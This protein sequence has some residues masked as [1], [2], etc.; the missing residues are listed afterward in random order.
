MVRK[1]K[2][3]DREPI[4]QISPIEYFSKDPEPMP[5]WLKN[6]T[7]GSLVRIRDIGDSRIVYYPGSHID[8]NP[9]RL[10]NTAHGAH[11]FIYVDYGYSRETLDEM[12]S[13]APLKGYHLHHEQA[14]SKFELFPHTLI[15]HT[16][17][18]EMAFAASGCDM[19]IAPKKA[20]AFLQIYERDEGYSE[21]YGAW[22]FA[23]IYIA[24]DANVTY[25]ALFSNTGVSPYACVVCANMGSEYS[26]FVSGSLLEKIAERTDCFPQY[27]LCR[28]DQGW[29]EYKMLQAVSGT[30]P[31]G[32]R[33][34]WI[35][36]DGA[37]DLDGLDENL[38]KIIA[39]SD[40]D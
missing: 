29:G 36:D 23:L 24:A 1:H 15:P 8:G 26:S 20:F 21:E 37:P 2:K 38:R 10:F 35:R 30:G 18:E 6:H 4:I 5:D 12:I 28:E 22:R 3:P 40:Q 19:S 33:R 27:L 14:V 31:C 13:Q 11:L 32:K 17:R 7:S 9:I 34:V 25:D 16:T 39:V